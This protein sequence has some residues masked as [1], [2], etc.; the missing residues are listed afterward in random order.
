MNSTLEAAKERWRRITKP[1]L[2]E[3]VLRHFQYGEI[4]GVYEDHHIC[5]VSPD[6]EYV[7]AFMEGPNGIFGYFPES[8]TSLCRKENMGLEKRQP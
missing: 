3:E 7:V 1:K 5:V 2:R 4:W 8:H 6:G